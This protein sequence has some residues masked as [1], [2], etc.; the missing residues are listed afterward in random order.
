MSLSVHSNV[1]FCKLIITLIKSAEVQTV[2]TV[3]L[4]GLMIHDDQN[5]KASY[6][7]GNKKRIICC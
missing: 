6:L 5:L 7:V 4:A 1:D 2:R 3:S